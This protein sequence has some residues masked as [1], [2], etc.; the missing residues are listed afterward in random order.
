MNFKPFPILAP[1]LVGA[2]TSSCAPSVSMMCHLKPKDNTLNL[3]ET[4]VKINGKN[5]AELRTFCNNI[6]FRVVG[7]NDPMYYQRVLQPISKH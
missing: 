1:F 4:S 6:T 2:F 3:V 5:E 7:A